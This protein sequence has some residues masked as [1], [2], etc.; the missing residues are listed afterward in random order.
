MP[1]TVT[2]TSHYAL[3]RASTKAAKA[4]EIEDAKH[5]NY[6]W[7]ERHVRAMINPIGLECGIVHMISSAAS[8]ADEHKEEYKS[9]IGADGVLGPEWEQIIRSTIALLN[10]NCGR[11]DCGALDALLRD[12]LTLEGFDAE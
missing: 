1:R 2:A 5:G 11:L 12:M 4:Q 3:I 7:G 9:R 6:A 10:G 8:Y